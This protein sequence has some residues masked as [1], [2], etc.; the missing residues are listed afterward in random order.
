MAWSVIGEQTEDFSS[1]ES[2]RRKTFTAQVEQEGC[3]A[4]SRS[5][6]RGHCTAFPY[7]FMVL[8]TFTFCLQ[9]FSPLACAFLV[10]LSLLM[11]F[12]FKFLPSNHVYISFPPCLFPL[13]FA[14]L[15]LHL[16][17]SC[18]FLFYSP[19]LSLTPVQFVSS[20]AQGSWLHTAVPGRLISIIP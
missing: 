20:F 12:A 8:G 11:L 13:L 2:M 9:F 1:V 16:S 17:L 15:L 3:V 4:Q 5:E 18:I 6:G 19:L 10:H 14:T 7:Y